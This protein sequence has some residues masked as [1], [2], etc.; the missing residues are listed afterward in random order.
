MFDIQGTP[1]EQDQISHLLDNLKKTKTGQE[2][3]SQVNSLVGDSQFI[4]KFDKTLPYRGLC[5]FKKI[6]L[7]PDRQTTPNDQ[8]S[9]L[10]HELAHAALGDVQKSTQHH[11]SDLDEYALIRLLIEAH[12]HMMG[13]LILQELNPQQLQSAKTATAPWWQTID[14]TT[15]KGRTLY[16]RK[17]LHL[18]TGWAEE[19]VKNLPT[20]MK[21]AH[22][23]NPTTFAAGCNTFLKAMDTD[24]TLD[25]ILALKPY[26]NRAQNSTSLNIWQ[27]LTKLFGR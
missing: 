22:D 12:G 18:Q 2:I 19:E 8:I 24:V 21:F 26:S 16:L 20:D 13:D 3:V 1:L 11:A 15:K 14:L 27:K 23:A 10:G 6:T 7:N 5:E 25:E 17:A 4:L 9:T